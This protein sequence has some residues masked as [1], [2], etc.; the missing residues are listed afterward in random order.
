MA[1]SCKPSLWRRGFP[2]SVGRLHRSKA[3]SR[4]SA[5]VRGTLA[6]LFQLLQ[7]VGARRFEQAVSGHGRFEIGDHERFGSEICDAFQD[8]GATTINEDTG[9][10]CDRKEPCEYGESAQ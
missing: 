7:C 3:L 9:C 10:F 1:M 4:M 6:A 2:R 8:I 5:R